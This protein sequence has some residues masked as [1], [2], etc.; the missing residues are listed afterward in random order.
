MSC[1][2]GVVPMAEAPPASLRNSP[3]VGHAGVLHRVATG[4]ETIRPI[5]STYE[6]TDQVPNFPCPGAP[7]R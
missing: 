3:G 5:R 4:R 2:V 6:G 1:E 7:G